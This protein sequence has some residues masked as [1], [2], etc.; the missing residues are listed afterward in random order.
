M[1]FRREL[2]GGL[3]LFVGGEGGRG[4]R[5]KRKG[6]KGKGKEMKGG[7]R[8][9]EFPYS[10]WRIEGRTEEGSSTTGG[11]DRMTD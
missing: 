4:G 8:N 2:G 11:E 7:V 6:E 9:R 1:G 3:A 5:G 10:Y